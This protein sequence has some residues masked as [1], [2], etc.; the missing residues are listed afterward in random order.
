MSGEEEGAHEDDIAGYL[1][2]PD[3]YEIA[4][5]LGSNVIGR[6]EEDCDVV[7]ETSQT[8]SGK[9]ARIDLI[10]DPKVDTTR[11][12]ITD[13][14][15]LNGYFINAD[16]IAGTRNSG[17][18]KTYELLTHDTVRFG[19]DPETYM[20]KIVDADGAEELHNDSV[21]E[22]FGGQAADRRALP[23]PISPPVSPRNKDIDNI[24]YELK[25]H[26]VRHVDGLKKAIREE[27]SKHSAEIEA[28]SQRIEKI[29][30][31]Q[32]DRTL[33]PP[34]GRKRPRRF[35]PAEAFAQ[36]SQGSPVRRNEGGP[37]P[38]MLYYQ[39]ASGVKGDVIGEHLIAREAPLEE[40][41]QSERRSQRPSTAKRRRSSIS[42]ERRSPSPAPASPANAKNDSNTVARQLAGAYKIATLFSCHDRR[43]VT[44]LFSA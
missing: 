34:R 3:G 35:N 44:R 19:F 39:T 21:A 31:S 14:G 25:R 43:R 36:A 26:S 16:H 28:L 8:I 20:L 37:P 41:E 42:S 2:S 38:A 13:L 29:E 9:H 32:R 5:R 11:C 15:S 12:S 7:L 22:P 10:Y 6:S 17:V 30:S 33:S 23:P 4:L 1:C 18:S 24:K 40:Q 27:G